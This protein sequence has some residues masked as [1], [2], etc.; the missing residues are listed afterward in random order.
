MSERTD[1]LVDIPH[2]RLDEAVAVLT[3]AFENDPAIRWLF[4]PGAAPYA[5]CLDAL[6]RFACL[7]RLELDWPLY[8]IEMD[9]RLAG[10]LGVTM[11]GDDAWPESLQQIYAGLGETVGQESIRRLETYSELADH[12]RP[13]EPHL[14]VGMVAVDPG[15]QGKGIGRQLLEEIQRMSEEHP[16]SIGVALDTENPPNLDFYQ[17]CGYVIV[18]E[19][20]L[21][22]AITVWNLFRAN[23][24][25]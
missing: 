25:S 15:F 5:E 16:E 6:F 18:A 20:R 7:V 14:H 9:G 12:D 8:G 4:E 10:V 13:K 17:R 11:P 19:H 21:E 23:R 24:T 3:T 1:D 22:D 2:E